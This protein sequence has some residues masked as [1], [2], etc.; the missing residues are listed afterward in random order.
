LSK[1]PVESRGESAFAATVARHEPPAPER[2]VA[3]A[4][5]N[6]DTDGSAM[7]AALRPGRDD[8]R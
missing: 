4:V 7:P 5:P 2:L 1:R 3:A 8:D 6:E